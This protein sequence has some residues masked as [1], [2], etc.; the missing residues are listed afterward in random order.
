MMSAITAVFAIVWLAAIPLV[1]GGNVVIET[2]QEYRISMV[3]P[4]SA[5]VNAG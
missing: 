5:Q 3:S 2:Y 4:T 1:A